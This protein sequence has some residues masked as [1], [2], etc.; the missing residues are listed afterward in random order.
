MLLKLLPQGIPQEKIAVPL[1]GELVGYVKEANDHAPCCSSNRTLQDLKSSFVESKPA[2][3][4]RLGAL[5]QQFDS[6][7]YSF[8]SLLMLPLSPSALSIACVIGS[9]TTP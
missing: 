6:L 2:L 4:D 5:R 3:K 7:F 8:V 9:D 1:F